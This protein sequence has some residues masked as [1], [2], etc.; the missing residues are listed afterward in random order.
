[1]ATELNYTRVRIPLLL[2]PVKRNLQRCRRWR[3]QQQQQQTNTN[4]HLLSR[5]TNAQYMNNILYITSTPTC[6]N[7][8]ALS[9][10]SLNFVLC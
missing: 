6:F 8:Y 3:R 1:M 7:A 2:A 4:N 10:G 5:P 9:S